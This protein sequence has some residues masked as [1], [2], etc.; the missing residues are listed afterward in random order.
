MHSTPRGVSIITHSGIAAARPTSFCSYAQ[1]CSSDSTFGSNT[2]SIGS[3]E[4][5]ARSRR[6]PRRIDTVHAQHQLAMTVAT[7]AHR[8]RDLRSRGF[9]RVGRHRIFQIEDD[10]VAIDVAR[11]L[12]R[13]RVGAGH[14][15][16]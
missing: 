8:R 11:F 9:L 1:T 4:A 2:A 13:A 12:H 15:Q 5:A 16:H 10:R 3:S 6:G 14:V 7:A